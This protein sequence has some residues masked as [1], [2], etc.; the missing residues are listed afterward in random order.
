MWKRLSI[1]LLVSVLAVSSAFA[2]PAWVYG[3]TK[4]STQNPSE[5]TVQ[6]A[7]GTLSIQE[8]KSLKKDSKESLTQLKAYLK[9]SGIE[10]QVAKEISRYVEQVE[11]GIDVMTKAYENEVKNHEQT[12][13]NYN[14][15][16]AD[17]AAKN[18]TEYAPKKFLDD[19]S[20]TINP[21]VTYSPFSQ[22]YGVGGSLGLG[23]KNVSVTVGAIRPSVKTFD[24][25]KSRDL[26]DV[27]LTAGFGVRF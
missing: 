25:I 13:S 15:L 21:F 18:G 23:Y 3:K 22:E 20:V 10:E 24:D 26:S 8:S 14:A 4:A 1:F 16:A 7:P 9:E 19:F 6:E 2:Y 5:E 12:Q 27:L 11:D 17:Y